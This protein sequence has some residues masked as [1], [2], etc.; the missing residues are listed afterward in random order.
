MSYVSLSIVIASKRRRLPFCRT[1]AERA[2]LLGE[3]R[4]LSALRSLCQHRMV[5]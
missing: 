1:S 5:Q 4:H 3:I 2:R